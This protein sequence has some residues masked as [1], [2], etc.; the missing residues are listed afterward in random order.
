[1]HSSLVTFPVVMAT[2]AC[3]DKEGELDPAALSAKQPFHQSLQGPAFRTSCISDREDD[4]CSER[5]L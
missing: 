2:F 3:L 1:M 4:R 5:L